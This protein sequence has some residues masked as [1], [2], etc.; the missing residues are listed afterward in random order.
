MYLRVFPMGDF[1]R[2]F[3]QIY[4]FG[5]MNIILEKPFQQNLIFLGNLFILK[6]VLQEMKLCPEKNILKLQLAEN[7]LRHIFKFRFP[8]RTTGVVRSG[9]DSWWDY[10]TA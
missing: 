2:V 1:T 7:I 5:C 8:A 4:N 3:V 6:S 10:K 9:G